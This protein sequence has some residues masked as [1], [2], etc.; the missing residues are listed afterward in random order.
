[1]RGLTIHEYT[2]KHKHFDF[3]SITFSY[4]SLYHENICLM[5]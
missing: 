3:Y 2:D 1:M 4:V 5:L